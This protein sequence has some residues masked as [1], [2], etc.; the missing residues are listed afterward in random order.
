MSFTPQGCDLAYIQIIDYILSFEINVGAEKTSR[1]GFRNP[2]FFSTY[3]DFQANDLVIIG[4]AQNTE[5][6]IS[7][8][9]EQ[10]IHPSGERE[11]LLKSAKTG[12]ECWWS[13]I[14]LFVM[15]R[16][17]VEDHPDWKWTNEQWEFKARW[18]KIQKEQDEYITRTYI[19]DIDD[20]YVR[21]GSRTRYS[22]NDVRT[23]LSFL[24][25]VSDDAVLTEIHKQ[26]IKGHEDAQEEQRKQRDIKPPV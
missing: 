4:A 10:L 22:I 8:L 23:S 24:W 15:D 12:N 19:E 17:T 11:F 6:R 14:S 16:K 21:I 3:D 5:Y 25:R 9:K 13:N 26:V 1:H 7:W 2:N 18:A 20:Q